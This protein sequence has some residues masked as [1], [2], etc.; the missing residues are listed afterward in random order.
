MNSLVVNGGD[1]LC[2]LAISS[3]VVP[4]LNTLEPGFIKVFFIMDK[5]L[6]F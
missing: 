4:I 3:P 5:D 1:N 6:F 2:T